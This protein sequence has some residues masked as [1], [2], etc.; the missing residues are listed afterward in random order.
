MSKFWVRHQQLVDN[1]TNLIASISEDF[2]PASITNPLTLFLNMCLQGYLIT[3]CQTAATFA[4][5]HSSSVDIGTRLRYRARQAAEEVIRVMQQASC[6]DI[7]QLFP[8]TPSCLYLASSVFILDLKAGHNI[9]HARERLKYILHS[10]RKFNKVWKFSQLFLE[11]LLH[12]LEDHDIEI[13]VSQTDESPMKC[14]Q[15]MGH[16]SAMGPLFVADPALKTEST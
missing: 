13:E 9:E 10:I 3:L 6:L 5:E 11:Q 14:L 16:W 7:R 8:T 15:G 1:T 4:N 2:R 12:N